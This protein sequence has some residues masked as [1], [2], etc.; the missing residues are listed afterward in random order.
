MLAI[1]S[2]ITQRKHCKLNIIDQFLGCP[3]IKYVK[4]L[5]A[6]QRSP[7]YFILKSPGPFCQ[8]ERL[9]RLFPQEITL[10]IQKLRLWSTY[11]L[12][13]QCWKSLSSHLFS[14][15]PAKWCRTDG[16]PTF[17]FSDSLDLTCWW[18]GA[19][20]PY[21]P[22][23]CLAV[24]FLYSLCLKVPGSKGGIIYSLKY[25]QYGCDVY[26]LQGSMLCSFS[27][28]AGGKH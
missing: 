10:L 24:H 27:P 3:Q 22:C 6:L 28:L 25:Q 20:T 21:W 26:I 2:L 18:N 23:R 4:S 11:S 17:V 14:P 16:T 19:F 15:F 9:R 1:W 5:I 13:C 7:L 8:A 12:Y